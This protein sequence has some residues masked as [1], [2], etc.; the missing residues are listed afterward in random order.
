MGCSDQLHNACRVVG[1][2]WHLPSHREHREWYLE[3]RTVKNPL[4]VKFWYNLLK[5]YQNLD[6]F[7]MKPKIKKVFYKVFRYDAGGSP[8]ERRTL[9]THWW[10]QGLYFKTKTR[11][12]VKCTNFRTRT[13]IWQIEKRPHELLSSDLWIPS[14]NMIWFEYELQ[15]TLGYDFRALLTRLDDFWHFESSQRQIPI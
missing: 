7:R 14:P 5:F 2:S 10:A 9:E 8:H 15:R 12:L 3:L 4:L 6:I 13:G 11:F 1:I